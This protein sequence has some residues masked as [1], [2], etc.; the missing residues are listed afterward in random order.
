MQ[1]FPIQ[2][3]IK[4]LKR[5]RLL[6]NSLY[7]Y[8]ALILPHPNKAKSLRV[9]N[10]CILCLFTYQPRL[11]AC[12]FYLLHGFWWK[13]IRKGFWD[14]CFWLSISS[15]HWH[16]Q[17]MLLAMLPSL[18]FSSQSDNVFLSHV[19][20]SPAFS[21]FFSFPR[22]IK[23]FSFKE[24]P[25]GKASVY[26]YNNQLAT[27]QLLQDTVFWFAWWLLVGYCH[28][29]TT[30]TE[31]HVIYWEGGWY[32]CHQNILFFLTGTEEFCT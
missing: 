19:I 4:Q 20:L 16:G 5:I 29:S 1:I 9:T 30:L 23:G 3:R 11:R 17:W 10:K 15:E 22:E 31:L 6:L 32:E 26:H 28:H 7:D 2:T 21:P 14:T 8:K 12:V 25:R 27:E 13:L 18:P 24:K